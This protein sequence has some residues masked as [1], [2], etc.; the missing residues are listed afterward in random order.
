M[1]ELNNEFGYQIIALNCILQKN[2]KYK[3]IPSLNATHFWR[4]QKKTNSSI[5][6]DRCQNKFSHFN[7]ITRY[8]SIPSE[9][10]S[11]KSKIF[12]NMNDKLFAPTFFTAFSQSLFGL[13]TTKN[14]A[15]RYSLKLWLCTCSLMQLLHN[16]GN[17]WQIFSMTLKQENDNFRYQNRRKIKIK[18]VFSLTWRES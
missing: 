3:I 15:F 4:I 17:R 13:H 16:L 11:R 7:R 18:N 14:E 6:I 5:F 12:L 9:D 10:R 1:K 2:K 8:N